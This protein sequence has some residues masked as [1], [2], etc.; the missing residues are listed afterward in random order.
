MDKILTYSGGWPI[1]TKDFDFIQNSY[2]AAIEAVVKATG[3]DKFILSGIIDVAPDFGVLQWQGTVNPG[4]VVIGGNIYFVTTKLTTGNFLQ[5]KYLNFE[6]NITEERTFKDG[7][8]HKIYETYTPSLGDS[9]GSIS[10]DLTM[11]RNYRYYLSDDSRWIESDYMLGGSR[12][13]N[14]TIKHRRL[15]DGKFER[16]VE[17]EHRSNRDNVLYRINGST[18]TGLV[19]SAV[20]MDTGKTVNLVEEDAVCRM[21]DASGVEE[22]GSVKIKAILR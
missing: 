12:G 1:L 3:A 8:A 6:K 15:A 17:V 5:Q 2:T 9:P 4:A 16:S 11:V 20:D 14:G 7:Q 13:S 10:I 22:T 19:A 18:T 21:Y